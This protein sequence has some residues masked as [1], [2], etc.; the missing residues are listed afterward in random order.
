MLYG[1]DL[2]VDDYYDVIGDLTLEDIEE[3][4]GEIDAFEI[5]EDFD[6]FI[7]FLRVC[8]DR[9]GGIEVFEYC[10]I[11]DMFLFEFTC[12]LELGIIYSSGQVDGLDI[13]SRVTKGRQMDEIVRYI[14]V[15][16]PFRMLL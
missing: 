3:L 10:S 16:N 6:V 7:G 4:Y 2:F 14:K 8:N 11:M 15:N 9:F 1:L 5:S 12:D 13:V